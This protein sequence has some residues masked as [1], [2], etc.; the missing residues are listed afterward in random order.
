MKTEPYSAMPSRK[1]A[2]M[3]KPKLRRTSRRRLRSGF[4]TVSSMIRKAV[5]ATAAITD[6][7]TMKGEPNQSSLLPSSS[8]VWSVDS[9]IAMVTMPAQ[10]PSRSSASFI[11]LG[12]R[13]Y[14][15]MPT[16]TAPGTRLT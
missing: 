14:Q 15:S 9:P 3:P 6:S 4:F 10:S 8:T 11:G 12:S 2:S 13:A 7:L 1:F 5:S 16:I